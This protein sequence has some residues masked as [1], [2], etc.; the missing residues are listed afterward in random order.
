MAASTLI[1][2]CGRS[3]SGK[4]TISKEIC[5]ILA[6]EGHTIGF[7]QMDNFYRHLSAED[8]EAALRGEYNFDCLDSFDMPAF[9]A[10]LEAAKNGESV[11]F[12]EYDHSTHSPGEQKCIGPAS[13]WV[14][15]GLYLFSEQHV[16]DLFDFK[17]FMDV[18]ADTSLS[19]RIRRDCVERARTVEGVLTQYEKFVK[20]A[21]L[22]L[23]E[24]FR[25]RSDITVLRGSRNRQALDA[26]LHYIRSRL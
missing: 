14:V 4:T 12:S 20:P 19:R 9:V 26:I 25:H 21:Y 23:V 5:R 6:S 3:S 10:Q 22:S 17:I 24:P 11:Y 8:H 16:V 2:V 13:V 7:L 18:D 15:E 1:G